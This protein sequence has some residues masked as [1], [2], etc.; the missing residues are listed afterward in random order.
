[1]VF[2]KQERELQMVLRYMNILNLLNKMMQL[3]FVI[4]N[5]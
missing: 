5:A 2:H 4:K 3:N 1:M